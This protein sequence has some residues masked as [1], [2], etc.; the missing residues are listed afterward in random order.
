MITEQQVME[1]LRQVMDPELRRNI[2][3]LGMVR[4]VR[5]RGKNIK[6]TIALTVANCPLQDSIATDAAKAVDALGEDLKVEIALTTMNEEEKARLREV[7]QSSP[8]QQP[9]FPAG[10]LN[11]VKTVIAVMS[12]KGGVG[13]S[14]VA[15]MIAVGLR[16]K[17]LRVGV[18][19]ADI[20]GPSIPKLFGVREAPTT[21]P[22]GIM[23]PQT[24][25]GIKLMSINLMLEDE[26]A[27]VIWRGPLI[28]SAINQFWSDVFWGDLD[29][30]VVDMPPGTS[31][32][33]LTVM[34]SLPV[35]GIV[36]VTSPQDLAE[37]VVRKAANMAA[38]LNTPLIGV[39]E[40]MSYVT[41]PKCG[42]R[43]ELF[44]KGNTEEMANAFNTRFLGKLGLDPE[45]AR[46]GDAGQI[47]TYANGEFAPLVEV[48]GQVI[49]A[50]PDPHKHTH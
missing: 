5:I 16:R 47:E 6:V 13:K 18:L 11:R 36:L 31:D 20:T 48:V 14:T 19:D 45:M 3:D 28:T 39:V 24:S 33:A 30:L 37:M 17:G 32:A 26:A 29:A 49:A 23:P 40:N 9:N 41:C 2:V 22:L 4:Q 8:Q 21:S 12:G 27:A 10:N 43:F 15:A 25:T 50:A 44:G 35:T 46:L 7:L 34:Q 1:A 42:E 38:H